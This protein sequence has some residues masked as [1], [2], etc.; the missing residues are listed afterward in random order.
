MHVNYISFTP[1]LFPEQRPRSLRCLLF[2]WYS[3][4]ASRPQISLHGSRWIALL[5]SLIRVGC[6]E[7]HCSSVLYCAHKMKDYCIDYY[8]RSQHAADQCIVF[9]STYCN[10]LVVDYHQ[11]CMSRGRS[12]SSRQPRGSTSATSASPR[13]LNASPRSHYS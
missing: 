1:K 4:R 10:T 2:S 9:S 13:L 5:I 12:L 11:W 7:I 8:E 3:T 6:L